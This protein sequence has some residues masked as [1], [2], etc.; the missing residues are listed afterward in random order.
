[1]PGE[2]INILGAGFSPTAAENVVT[3][4]QGGGGTVTATPTQAAP[5]SLMVQVPAGAISG[6]VSVTVNGNTT[7]RFYFNAMTPVITGISPTAGTVATAVKLDGRSFGSQ[8]LQ[9]AVRFNGAVN[10]GSIVAWGTNQVVVKPPAPSL[11]SKVS[12]PL[13]AV[14]L[15]G[16]VSQPFGNFTANA[17]VVEGFTGAPGAG[18]TASWTGGI[19][20]AGVADTAF[21]Q[22]NFSANTNTGNYVANASGLT[23]SPVA[24]TFPIAVSGYQYD[25]GTGYSA[26]TQLG[27]DDAYFFAPGTSAKKVRRYNLY[28][29]AFED[30][31][32]L[33]YGDAVIWNPNNGYASLAASAYQA[34]K[35]GTTWGGAGFTT[36]TD[37]SATNLANS[38]HAMFAT[39][40]TNYY[41]YDCGAGHKVSLLSNVLG[42]LGS[43]P[44]V[45]Y[46]CGSG[47]ASAA[48]FTGLSEVLT[49]PGNAT[50]SITALD[51]VNGSNWTKNAVALP[52]ALDGTGVSGVNVPLI[53]SNGVHLFALGRN[54][55]YNGNA[56]SLF[57]FT[58]SGGV[59]AHLTSGGN[60]TSTTA[61]I[62]LTANSVWNT[63]T[64]TRNVPANT[65][66]VIDVLDGTSGA[67]L[68]SNIASGASI[69]DL[70]A[71]SIKLRATV[72]M[73][74]TG[75]APTVTNWSVT[76]R[77]AY[78]VSPAYD[79]GTNFATYQ[80][81][82]VTSNG[83]AGTHYAITYSDSADGVTWGADVSNFTTLTRRYVR[84]KVN[85]KQ[86]T[87]QI[88]GISLP[89]QY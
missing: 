8:G 5:H 54:P 40:G 27:V 38:T 84:F 49:N 14:M 68:K 63:V 87:T 74:G 20:Q 29:G 34:F 73:G 55:S 86:P 3:F 21:T 51:R 22:T 61:A 77:R 64:F 83:A 67:V 17:S 18:T 75:T 26:R 71:T 48:G 89:Y 53:G 13:S 37:S 41:H 65:N 4:Q 1:M 10:Q 30:E 76:T 59:L 56:I 6:P 9:S 31:T 58:Y 46:G 79:S 33:S 28:T 52:F 66:C 11:I 69:G 45:S 81:P 88:T 57:R 19:L 36:P 85:L 16:S 82:V 32:T 50:N 24:G 62:P 42:D 2:T 47:P 23:V 43:W 60:A 35:L 80:A 70:T 44:G 15:T 25:A 7:N 78:A 72:S 12:G 39:D